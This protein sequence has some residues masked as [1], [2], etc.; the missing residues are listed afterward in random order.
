[1]RKACLCVWMTLFIALVTTACSSVDPIKKIAET[2]GVDL[3]SGIVLQNVD[4][5][6]GFHGDGDTYMIIDFSEDEGKTFMKELENSTGWSRLPLTDNLKTIMYG[7]KS[8][9]KRVGPYVTNDNGDPY[10]PVVK[11]G[12][13]FFLDRHSER[14]N[15]K[16]D[17]N[18]LNRASY[19]FTIAIYD[20][21]HQIL[22][23]YELDT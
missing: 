11:N 13:Y 19:N 17:L 22:Y 2:L 4:S 23:Y 12:Y 20:L 18:I 6:D 16:D 9:S 14:K 15:I 21:D 8:E 3:S 10:F 1:M 5:H 7:T